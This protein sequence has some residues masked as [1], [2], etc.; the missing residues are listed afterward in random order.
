MILG[1]KEWVWDQ[2]GLDETLSQNKEK[3]TSPIE[4]QNP[5]YGADSE[6]AISLSP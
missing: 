4:H 5:T 2:V 1:A 3:K 6:C